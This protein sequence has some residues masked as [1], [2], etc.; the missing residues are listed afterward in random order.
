[1]CPTEND[2]KIIKT[3]RRLRR[4]MTDG[5]RKLWSELKEF[6]RLYGV[7]F[8]KQ[9]PIKPY[10]V[11]FASH[12]NRLVIEVDGQHH[13]TPDG[14]NRDVVRDRYLASRGYRILR[15]NTGELSDSFD[16]CVEEILREI[17]VR[18]STHPTHTLIEKP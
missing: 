5:E 8:R 2:A 18:V 1:M 15:F 12:D 13:F 17:G 11:D 3:A 4:S 7:H 16:G 14:R 10:V 6:R 9:A